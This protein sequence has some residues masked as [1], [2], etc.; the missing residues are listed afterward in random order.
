MTSKLL[1]EEITG[2][3]AAVFDQLKEPVQ[4]LF[5]GRKEGCDYCDDTRQ[6]VEEIVSLSDK[7]VISIYDLDEDAA[8]AKQYRV[9]KAPGLVIAG[10]DG[11]QILDYGIRFAGIPSGH[12]FS[13]LIHDLVLVSGRDSGLE[14]STRDTLKKL[15][16]PVLLQVFVTPT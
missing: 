8:V 2:Q 3:V 12:E 9:D 11:G 7:L 5:F 1:N 14:Q 15:P 10:L 13:S 4:I 6:L 16:Q